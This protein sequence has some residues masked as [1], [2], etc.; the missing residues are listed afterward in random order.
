VRRGKGRVGDGNVDAEGY[1]GSVKA[2]GD[3]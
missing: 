1:L 3:I 2:K